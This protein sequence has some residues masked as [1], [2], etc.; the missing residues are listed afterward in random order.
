[1]NKIPKEEKSSEA[2]EKAL[3][4]L[5][6]DIAEKKNE[7][8]QILADAI[9]SNAEYKAQLEQR[10]KTLNK[11]S[12]RP[13]YICGYDEHGAW[14]KFLAHIVSDRGGN[15]LD[16]FSQEPLDFPGKT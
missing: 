8:M 14:I 12:G 2:K 6:Q 16:T 3:N 5:A 9:W 11:G 1:M 13:T 4:D 10:L 15:I 7:A